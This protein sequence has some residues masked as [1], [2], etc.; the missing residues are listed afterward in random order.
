[1]KTCSSLSPPPPSPHLPSPSLL[2][3]PPS[4]HVCSQNSFTLIANSIPDIWSINATSAPLCD[5]IGMLTLPVCQPSCCLGTGPSGNVYD[6]SGTATGALYGHGYSEYGQVQ[7]P[8]GMQL[9][10]SLEEVKD[11]CAL[12]STC[13]G[14]IV[15]SCAGGKR[16]CSSGWSS[17]TKYIPVSN[18]ADM[19]PQ[20]PGKNVLGVWVKTC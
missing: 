1:M 15:H 5:E 17:W 3:S 20:D 13:A 19:V 8:H 11:K 10:V 9:G 7:Y 18:V 16:I 2:P 12:A 14:F 6:S 4:P